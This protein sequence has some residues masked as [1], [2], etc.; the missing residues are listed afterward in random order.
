MKLHAGNPNFMRVNSFTG[1]GSFSPR[2]SNVVP[3]R[4]DRAPSVFVPSEKHPDAVQPPQ[5]NV[6]DRSVYTQENHQPARRGALDFL[7]IKSKGI[8]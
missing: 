4:K 5:M 2:T 1:L 7:N 6:W 3:S 8:A